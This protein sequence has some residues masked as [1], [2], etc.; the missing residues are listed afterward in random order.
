M[1]SFYTS[2]IQQGNYLYVRGID[3]DGR[4]QK[5]IA[6]KPYLFAASA[7]PTGITDIHGS[8]VKRVDFDNVWEA[9]QWSEQWHGFD[10]YGSSRWA[11]LYIYD[12]YKNFQPDT[13]KINVVYI[14]IE[15]KSDDGFPEPEKAE[16]EIT[17]I[18]I[19]KGGLCVALGIRD[20]KKPNLEKYKDVYY[21]KCKDE[22]HLLNKFLQSWERMD[23]DAVTGWNSEFFDIPYL[24]NRI[25]KV[26]SKDSHKRLSPWGIVKEKMVYRAGS[27]KQSQTYSILGVADLDY[28][29][30]YKKFRLQPRES[31]RLD[32]I[33]EIEI[34]RKKVDYSEYGNLHELYKN[35][36]QKFIEYNIDDVML[37]VELEKQLG[38][39]DQIF[40]IAYDA[41]VNYQDTLASV[42]LWDVIIHNYLMDT[43]KVVTY[44][45]K[46]NQ[47]TG[48][49]VGGHV[50]DPHVGMHEW[51]MSFDLNSLYPHL[52]MQYN[53]SP[54][55]KR[56]VHIN[57]VSVDTMLKQ[58]VNLD[59]LRSSHCTLTPNGQ[60][61]DTIEQGFLPAIMEKMYNDRVEYKNKM[62]DAKREYQKNPT[63]QL[64][65]DISRYHNLQ[66]SKK[67]QLNSAYGALANQYFRWFDNENAE[68][69]T[70]AGQLSIRWI[71]NKMN[72][73][74]NKLLSTKNKD[75]VIAGDTD[76]I[77]VC[78]DKLVKKVNPDD[79]I[80][81]LDFAA[82]S[83]IEPFIDSAYKDLANYTNARSQKMFMKRENIADKAIWTAK[84]RY[85]MHVYD[86]EGVRYTDPKMKMMGIEAIRSSTPAVCRDE[87]KKTLKLIMTTDEGTVQK[88]ISNFRTEFRTL[89]YEDIAFPR[90][91]NFVKWEK[92]AQGKIYPGT[93][94]DKTNIY[95][96]GT[97]IQVKGSLIY[98]HL[99]N[100]YNL[101][102]KYEEIK[103]GEKIKFCYL[104]KANPIFQT[105][106]AS[107]A[108]LPEEFALDEFLD[109]ETQFYKGYL[110]P[111]ETILDAVGWDV[112]KT[113]SIEDFFG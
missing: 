111:M 88:Y 73:Y 106:I 42:L 100:K 32:Y 66:H 53:I 103:S 1:N 68:A 112:E 10:I 28:L 79:P 33:A 113:N 109:F 78:F 11:Y 65:V 56:D 90:S 55:C 27:D 85:I 59:Q 3:A 83:K 87:I 77:Y 24:V 16:K 22:T 30:I 44:D 46:S 19:I 91:C 17:A 95:K 21:I 58:E 7:K 8:N 2:V 74:L 12:T 31:Y 5:K 18:T 107:P 48:S 84:K 101:E 37:I 4:F 104:V 82:K 35:N 105:V 75:Y 99:L 49:I 62:I 14:D 61:Y 15:V 29:K 41:K 40:S 20:F 63:K 9:R 43:N 57:N 6:Y 89:S 45:R 110:K 102:K 23:P 47:N 94:A 92:N 108:G 54:E 13:S 71:E 50:K 51:V 86:E 64:E 38:Y 52:I 34:G 36:H 97:P 26:C 60:V 76:S 93:Y 69:I 72:D 80:E 39:I 70:M 25:Q 67:I 98:N 81:F 96:K